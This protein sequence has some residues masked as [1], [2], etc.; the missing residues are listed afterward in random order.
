[1]CFLAAIDKEPDSRGNRREMEG[2]AKAY[3]NTAHIYS[4]QFNDYT[5]CYRL[6]REA[7]RICREYGLDKTLAHVYVNLSA[8]ISSSRSTLNNIDPGDDY[9]AESMDYLFKA[10][11]YARKTRNYEV[12]TYAVF[13]MITEANPDSDSRIREYAERY[14]RSKIPYSVA[15]ALYMKEFCKAYLALFDGDMKESA[16]R[17]HDLSLDTDSLNNLS[18]FSK[19]A[20][21]I[22][23]ISRFMEAYAMGAGGDHDGAIR[24]AAEVYSSADQRNDA[25]WK[26]WAAG[27]MYLLNRD[28]G[29][30][31]EADRWLLT[32]YRTRELIA[33]SVAES[34]I[35]ELDLRREIEDYRNDLHNIRMQHQ[36]G[37]VVRWAIAITALCVIITLAVIA[38]NYRRRK[39]YVMRLYEKNLQLLGQKEAQLLKEANGTKIPE[40]DNTYVVSK[41]S[42]TENTPGSVDPELIS[43]V[44]EVLESDAVFDPDFQFSRLC[45]AVGSNTTYVSKAIGAIYGKTFRTVMT[46]KRIAEACRR[47][48]DPTAS[49]RFTVEA[50]CRELGFRSR[51][52]FSVAFKNVTGLTPTEYRNAARRYSPP[53]GIVEGD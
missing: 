44:K 52:A 7:E 4:V 20:P 48:D 22:N 27:N 13:N 50:I 9:D 36:R 11:E 6:L 51:A 47:F 38:V 16:R 12:M 5:E 21:R 34:T 25:R 2:V 3:V 32:Y 39:E 23:E 31:A 46:E 1:M 14:V 10:Y 40:S 42:R 19:M 53:S 29:R 17:F 28:A 8:T 26:M 15:D 41:E 43:K 18:K 24:L 45:T 30:E 33:Q 37:L 35:G 49:D